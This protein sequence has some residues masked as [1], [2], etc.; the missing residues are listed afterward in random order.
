MMGSFA[1]P[2]GSVDT[3][4][5]TFILGTL[6]GRPRL[7]VVSTNAIASD[8]RSALPDCPQS[9]RELASLIS[10]AAILLGLIPVIDPAYT[11]IDSS[12]HDPPLGYGYP[13]H[14]PDPLAVY[15]FSPGPPRTLPVRK[16]RR[17]TK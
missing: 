2:A 9:D 16:T 8:I 17:F 3:D 6:T 14:R 12:E 13:A 4:I 11:D 1:E 7:S 10:E 15:V 5:W